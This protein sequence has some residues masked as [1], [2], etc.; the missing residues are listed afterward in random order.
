PGDPLQRFGPLILLLGTV[1]LLGH[2]RD[3][4]DLILCVILISQV[5]VWLFAT[6]LFARFAVVLL[7]PLVLLAGRVFIG[8]TSKYRVGA[9]CLLIAIGA[10]W[11]L[12]FA[13]KLIANER[14]TGAPASLIYDGELP[15]FEY[16]KTINHE[17]PAG[18]RLLLVGDAKAFYFQ[19]NVDYCVAFNRSSFAEAVRQAEDEQEVVTWLRSRGYTHVLV[20]WSEIRRL[21]STYGF[22]PEVNEGLFDRLASTGLS[23]VEE[24]IHPQTGARYVTLYKVSD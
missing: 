11:N 9:V 1:G 16:F 3:R 5:G 22:A 14:A 19:R 18:A 10:G 24:F 8:S 12:T 4:I 20:N 23:I 6:H 15:G 17:L 21:R 13:A 7:I 2:R